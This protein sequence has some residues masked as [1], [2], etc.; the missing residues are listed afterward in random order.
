MV[1]VLVCMSVSV[2]VH[3]ARESVFVV[4]FWKKLINKNT[5]QMLFLACALR[6]V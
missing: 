5:S 4:G 3:V 2:C 6:G 1:H